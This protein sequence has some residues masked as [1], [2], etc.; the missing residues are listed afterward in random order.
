MR[1]H[2]ADDPM[3]CGSRDGESSPCAIAMIA[4]L[5][6]TTRPQRIDERPAAVCRD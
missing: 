2:F 4:V 1:H 3:G 6:P 5:M